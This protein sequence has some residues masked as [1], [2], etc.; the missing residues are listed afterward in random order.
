MCR[1]RRSDQSFYSRADMLQQMEFSLGLLTPEIEK[2]LDCAN[3][4]SQIQ[5]T[6][7]KVILLSHA[8]FFCP[9]T[10]K[11]IDD[12]SRMCK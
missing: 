5:F 12:V 4:S 2:R 11:V 6:L 8:L 1:E 7:F 9:K 3:I 10:N